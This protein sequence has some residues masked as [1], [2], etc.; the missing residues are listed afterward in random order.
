MNYPTIEEQRAYVLARY[1]A[2]PRPPGPEWE[3]RYRH[4]VKVKTDHEIELIYRFLKTG[5]KATE[6]D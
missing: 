4:S 2:L 3:A 5:R 6:P 1:M